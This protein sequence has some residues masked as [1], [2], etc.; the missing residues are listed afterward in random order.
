M[1]GTIIVKEFTLVNRDAG[2]AHGGPEAALR[3]LGLS[4]HAA[5]IWFKLEMCREDWWGSLL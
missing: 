2:L 4:C 5:D 1:T 3:T